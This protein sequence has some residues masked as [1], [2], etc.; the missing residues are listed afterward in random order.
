M[1]EDKKVVANLFTLNYDL[2]NNRQIQ[3]NGNFHEGMTAEQK[4]AELDGIVDVAE[5][6]RA[7]LAIELLEM[8]IKQ[9]VKQLEDTV[10]QL[11]SASNEM[12]RVKDKDRAG[13]VRAKVDALNTNVRHLRESIKEGEQ[14]IEKQRLFVLQGKKE[15]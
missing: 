12:Q 11:E 10:A 3:I 2:G 5:R 7:R 9:Q 4:N 6:Q 13:G 15:A 14:E 8:R 1:S